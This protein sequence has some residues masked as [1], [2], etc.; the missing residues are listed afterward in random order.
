MER[1][2][3]GASGHIRDHVVRQRPK[4]NRRIVRVRNVRKGV[5]VDA[6]V[7]PEKALIDVKVTRRLL[8]LEEERRAGVAAIC[9]DGGGSKHWV[10]RVGD[11]KAVEG[12]G[13]VGRHKRLLGCGGGEGVAV[14]SSGASNGRV[15]LSLLRLGH[16]RG[17]AKRREAHLRYISDREDMINNLRRIGPVLPRREGHLDVHV[18]LSVDV[19]QKDAV[20][21]GVVVVGVWVRHALGR[22]EAGA[23]GSCIVSAAAPLLRS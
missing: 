2:A 14:V 3:G 21:D 9:S 5:V 13:A 17:H 12:D 6:V 16:R 23:G 8:L 4:Q 18:H 19:C 7:G 11:S 1:R 20:V 15:L 22:G 10:A